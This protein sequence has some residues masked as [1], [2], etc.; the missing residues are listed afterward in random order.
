MGFQ[1][2]TPPNRVTASLTDSNGADV[3][4][5]ALSPGS[6]RF[7]AV[8]GTSSIKKHWEWLK[9]N[10]NNYYYYGNK[11]TRK[12]WCLEFVEVEVGI[13]IVNATGLV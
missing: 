1:Y 6:D 4:I 3:S 5:S 2:P 9:N 13:K 12:G 10:N 8:S 7:A 11:T